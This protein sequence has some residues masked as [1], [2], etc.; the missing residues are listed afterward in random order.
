[1]SR[2][3]CSLFRS[4]LELKSSGAI[5]EPPKH[6]TGLVRIRVVIPAQLR[7]AKRLLDPKAMGFPN[8]AYAGSE[9]SKMHVT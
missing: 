7:A 1:M 2:G 5:A 9:L 6:R 4:T 8:T 3:G